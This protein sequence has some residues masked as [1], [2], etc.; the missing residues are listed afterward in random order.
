MSNWKPSITVVTNESLLEYQNDYSNKKRRYEYHTYN[1][2]R[3][4]KA[5]LLN[6]LNKSVDGTLSVSRSRRG[7][8]GEWFETYELINGKP[9]IVKEGWM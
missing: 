4:L 8:W 7:E 1:T 6:Q 9:K 3:L 5:D 2:Y